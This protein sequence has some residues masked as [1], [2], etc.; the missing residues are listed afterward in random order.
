MLLQKAQTRD[1]IDCAGSYWT[2]YTHQ[3]NL[4]PTT[5]LLARK[6][7]GCSIHPFGMQELKAT[8][9]YAVAL[10]SSPRRCAVSYLRRVGS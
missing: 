2:T 5:F 6:T 3:I 7:V 4:F 8:V 1:G 9:A 10:E